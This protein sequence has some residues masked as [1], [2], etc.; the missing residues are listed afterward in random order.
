MKNLVAGIDIGE[1]FTT[2]ALVDEFGKIYAKET[3]QTTDFK[4]FNQYVNFLKERVDL[5]SNDLDIP[6]IISGV[7]ISAPNGNYYTGEIEN[8]ANLLWKGKLPIV[9]QIKT[10]FPDVP[11]IL[12]NDANAAA[13]GEM[14]YG[15]ANGL[16]NFVVVT[17]GTGLG[18]G[19]VVDGNILYGHDGFAG[20]FGHIRIVKE[21]GRDCGCG[22]KGCLECYASASGLKKTYLELLN[23]S[24]SNNSKK[25]LSIKD[26]SIKDI[27]SAAKSGDAIAKQ[28]FDITGE[29]LGDSLSNLVTIISPQAIFLF[30]GLAK[31]GDLILN[32]IKK[33]FE[34][35]ILPL[36]K[37][38][39]SINISSLDS[40][41]ASILGAA[42]LAVDQ[43]RKRRVVTERRRVF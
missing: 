16:K 1:R 15:G 35:N 19:I 22:R 27:A 11:V 3:F 39:I 42:A 17:L 32:P 21:N 37:G 34:K 26:I 7:G 41:N 38:K 43:M 28:C 30:G 23:N 12:T 8:A 36:W 10:K 18:S 6:H 2:Y 29:I 9:K 33:R 25:E 4:N 40:E 13:L 20:E 5:L 14:I 24:Q 31:T